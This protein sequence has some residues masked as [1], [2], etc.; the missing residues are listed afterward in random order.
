MSEKIFLNEEKSILVILSIILF[1]IHR[2][3]HTRKVTAFG[4]LTVRK[5]LIHMLARGH[6]QI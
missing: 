3:P 1:L 5:I 2:Q 4:R 6:Q